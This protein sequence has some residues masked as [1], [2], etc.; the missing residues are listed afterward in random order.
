MESTTDVVGVSRWRL[1]VT[2]SL[3]AMFLAFPVAAF[4]A[5]VFRFPIP[6]VGYRSGVDA[7]VPALFATLFYGLVFGGLVWLGLFGAV[8]GLFV[9]SKLL[10]ERRLALWVARIWALGVAIL[11]LS[12]LSVLDMIIGPF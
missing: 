1:A 5:L 7:V 10:V 9:P 12:L 2:G 3:W 11:N 6:F 8:A 4:I